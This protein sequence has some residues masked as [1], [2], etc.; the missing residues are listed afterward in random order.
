MENSP[1]V[2][3]SLDH[4]VSCMSVSL[5]LVARPNSEFHRE[6]GVNITPVGVVTRGVHMVASL[7]LVTS[8]LVMEM[9][10]HCIL[11]PLF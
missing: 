1:S 11:K 7:H 5:N 9:T 4:L 8:C 3:G 10:N 2:Q 6:G